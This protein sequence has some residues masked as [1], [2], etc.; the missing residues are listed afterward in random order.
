MAFRPTDSRV[1]VVTGPMLHSAMRDSSALPPEP[2][3]SSV[4]VTV[5][6]EVN[7]IASAVPASMREPSSAPEL[8][9]G[10]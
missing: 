4:E 7:R 2:S 10:R 5:E 8:C 9:S 6:L 1:R 3:A